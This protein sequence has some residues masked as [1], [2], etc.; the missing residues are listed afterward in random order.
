M[1]VS[2]LI[3]TIIDNLIQIDFIGF[4]PESIR[5]GLKLGKVGIA[6]VFNILFIVFEM[7]SIIKNMVLCKMPIPKKLQNFLEKI[8]KEFTGEI[9]EGEKNEKD[10]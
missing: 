2:I 9:K 6:D 1:V 8:M 5:E 4:I 10:S 3:L 7:L